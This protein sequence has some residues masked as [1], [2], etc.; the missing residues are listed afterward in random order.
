MGKESLLDEKNSGVPGNVIFYE[1][2]DRR[3]PRQEDKVFAT[4]RQVG[5]VLSG[6]YSPLVKGPIGSAWIESSVLHTNPL[7]ELTAEVRS[8]RVSLRRE[9][10]VLRRLRSKRK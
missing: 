6:G 5:R 8:N 4:D 10:P 9:L 7:V 1:V 2:D 3:I